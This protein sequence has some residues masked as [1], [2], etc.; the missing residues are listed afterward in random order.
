MG[1]K[2]HGPLLRFD[3]FMEQWATSYYGEGMPLGSRGDFITAPEISQLFGEI[4]GAWLTFEMG[5]L[6]DQGRRTED[7][8]VSG[9]APLDS[10][11][12]LVELGPGNGT[13]LLDVCRV[14][15]ASL[16]R[17]LQVKLLEC[18][19]HLKAH[20]ER[21]LRGTYPDLPCRWYSKADEL[22]VDLKQETRLSGPPAD[23]VA[24]SGGRPS[25]KSPGPI[26]FLANEF[27]DVLPIRQFHYLPILGK[28]WWELYIAPP[29]GQM[30]DA[31]G[32]RG[33]TGFSPVLRPVVAGSV[34]D[35]PTIPPGTRQSLVWSYAPQADT[36]WQGIC[37][38]LH[39]R[40]GGALAID[41][42]G[43]GW[44]QTIQ[45]LHRHKRQNMFDQ[46]VGCGDITAHVNFRRLGEIGRRAGVRMDDPVPQG[47]FLLAHG[48][49]ARLKALCAAVS[50]PQ[51]DEGR[52]DTED[53]LKQVALLW[54][55]FYRLTHPYQMGRLFK[56]LV[57][58]SG[59]GE[60]A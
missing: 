56:V 19:P 41:Y 45:V 16:R 27:F 32:W 18:N 12:T 17:G 26:F 55:Q 15:P 38:V 43:D 25:G 39:Q 35:L 30:V 13:L 28:S 59:R 2:Q 3:A 23:S 31:G 36:L 52:P 51:D 48:I 8:E 58:K 4:V 44:G 54:S 47:D 46:A 21:V 1:T 34:P 42:G 22:L 33:V 7:G 9:A 49:Q 37:E 5:C 57:A 24:S 50:P 20:Q 6:L 40:S 60:G 29:R 11:C 10:P 14:M 53:R